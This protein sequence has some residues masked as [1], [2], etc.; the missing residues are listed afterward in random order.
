MNDPVWL[1]SLVPL[2]PLWHQ[3]RTEMGPLVLGGK[4]LYALHVADMSFNQATY[5]FEAA[6]L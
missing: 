4:D 6:A 2:C 1:Y 5:T 3:F